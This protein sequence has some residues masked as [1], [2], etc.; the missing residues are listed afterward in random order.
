V[1]H[2]SGRHARQS[3]VPDS[4]RR[5]TSIQKPT[6][7]P[8]R[9][10]AIIQAAHLQ[11]HRRFLA[12]PARA[13][14]AVQIEIW[15]VRRACPHAG[16]H[17]RTPQSLPPPSLTETSATARDTTDHGAATAAPNMDARVVS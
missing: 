16:G 17:T 11:P 14:P 12:A 3:R 1:A 6:L 5:L 13:C 4:L 2:S 7:K 10:P 15:P 9:T 8:Q